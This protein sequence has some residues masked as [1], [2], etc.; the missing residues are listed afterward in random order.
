LEACLV[1]SV[2]QNDQVSDQASDQVNKLLNLLMQQRS[3]TSSEMMRQ[4]NLKHKPTFRKNYILP[5]LQQQW[6]EMTQP[7]TPKS[8]TQ[9]YRITPLGKQLIT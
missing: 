5:A 6:I 3:L 4:L 1:G 9:K 8:P 7:D 2:D